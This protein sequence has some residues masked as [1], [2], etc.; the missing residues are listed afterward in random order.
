MT[1]YFILEKFNMELNLRTQFLSVSHFTANA[2]LLFSRGFILLLR[3][4]NSKTAMRNILQ[5]CVLKE[6]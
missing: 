3:L 6:I 2:T 1:H 4:P 5:F